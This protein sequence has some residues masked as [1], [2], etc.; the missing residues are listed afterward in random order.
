V[1]YTEN[2]EEFLL[3]SPCFIK[4]ISSNF[5]KKPSFGDAKIVE[6]AR[7][8]SNMSNVLEKLGYKEVRRITKKIELIKYK[9]QNIMLTIFGIEKVNDNPTQQNEKFV[10]MNCFCPD[11]EIENYATQM[12]AIAE[13]FE[14]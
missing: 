3:L 14:K 4:Y 8:E 2:V 1:N 9:N 10:E 11:S 12:K 5:V 13:K 6:L 7:C